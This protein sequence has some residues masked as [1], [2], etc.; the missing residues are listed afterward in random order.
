[1]IQ[2]V[3]CQKIF[4][5]KNKKDLLDSFEDKILCLPNHKNISKK[6]ISY[7]VDNIKYFYNKN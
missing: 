4:K 2:Y 1:M 6:Y 3:D 5:N 7:I